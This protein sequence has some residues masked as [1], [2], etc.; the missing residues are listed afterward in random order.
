MRLISA[1][2]RN[3]KLLEDV[4]LDFSTD[5]NRPLTVIRAEN[6]AGKTS[7]LYALL[8]SFYGSEGLPKDARGLR[9]TSTA[10]E[11]DVP[12]EVQARIEFEHFDEIAGV[13]TR[14]RLIR[15]VTETPRSDDN[16]ERGA[17]RLRLLRV[18]NRGDEEIRDGAQ[19]LV[20]KLVPPR[21]AK[22][23]FTNGDDVQQFISGFA[24]AERQDSVHEAIRL[25]LGLEQLEI[26]REDLATASPGLQERD[27]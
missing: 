17:A 7:L 16:H 3:F 15:S 11:V 19:A 10:S 22:I 4:D 9:L 18:T 13:S 26:A 2:V 8:W 5:P 27:R 24:S 25:L 23:F 1:H 14:Y 12:V 6:G 21:L 20:L